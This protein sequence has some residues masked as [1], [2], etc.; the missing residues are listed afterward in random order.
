MNASLRYLSNTGAFNGT[1][2]ATFN[3]NVNNISVT[4]IFYQDFLGQLRRA[5]RTGFTQSQ[6]YPGPNIRPIVEANARNATPLA[7]VNYT[8]ITTGIETVYSFTNMTMTFESDEVS[9]RPI[10]STSTHLICS[11]M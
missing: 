2:L 9:N 6:W 4:H 11:K 5:Q 1:R 7:C 10:S 8:N 3:T